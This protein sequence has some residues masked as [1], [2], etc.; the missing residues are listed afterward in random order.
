MKQEGV[1]DIA[2]AVDR[3]FHYLEHSGDLH[4]RRRARLRRRVVEVVESRVRRRLWTNAELNAWLDAQ[5]ES[6]VSG[7][8]NPFEVADTLLARG[9]DVL[10]GTRT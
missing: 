8:R 2:G 3:H 9:A 7:T 6:L 1:D 5:L 10:S 4:A